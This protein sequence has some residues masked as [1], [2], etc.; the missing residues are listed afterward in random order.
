MFL[1]GAYGKMHRY[2]AGALVNSFRFFSVSFVGCAVVRYV[3][4][5]V[6]LEQ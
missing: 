4:H 3:L 6:L 5:L 2:T 1:P